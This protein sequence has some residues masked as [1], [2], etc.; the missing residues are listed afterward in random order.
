MSLQTLLIGWLLLSIAVAAILCRLIHK[1]KVAD[2]ALRMQR[3]DQSP[4]RQTTKA[5]RDDDDSDRHVA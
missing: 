3:A 5:K 2:R 1:A 4:H